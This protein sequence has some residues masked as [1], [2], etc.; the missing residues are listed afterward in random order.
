MPTS[1]LLALYTLFHPT[2]LLIASSPVFGYSQYFS[3]EEALRV[4]E[5]LYANP[6]KI[7]LEPLTQYDI[8]QKDFKDKKVEQ[9]STTALGTKVKT[10]LEFV[11]FR[12]DNDK[13]GAFDY[14][15]IEIEQ[16]DDS[17]VWSKES[18]S[19]DDVVAM[20]FL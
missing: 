5:Y 4:W 17:R 14:F 7:A 11:D 2:F 3:D 9:I 15:F 20:D 13:K 6:S 8:L 19:F 16:E 18:F 12:L 10:I 1:L